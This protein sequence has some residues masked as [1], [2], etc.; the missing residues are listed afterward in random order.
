MSDKI[1]YQFSAFPV[2]WLISPKLTANEKIVLAV[3]IALGNG[4]GQSAVGYEKLAGYCC[5]SR[6]YLIELINKL[7]INGYIERTIQNNRRKPTL[8]RVC[9]ERVGG[10][11]QAAAQE[12]V[13][14]DSCAEKQ[15][16]DLTETGVRF[17][18][19][20]SQFEQT[21]NIFKQD[22]NYNKGKSQFEQTLNKSNKD[23]Y[24]A[25]ADVAAVRSMP[26]GEQVAGNT[27][28][29]EVMDAAKAAKE[30][31][32]IQVISKYFGDKMAW[33]QVFEVSNKIGFRVLGGR[34][35][36]VEIDVAKE[37]AAR[38]NFIFTDN[39]QFADERILTA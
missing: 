14:A 37:F 36:G 33:I 7:E 6:T 29:K 32:S 34:I 3:L 21:L 12:S 23:S 26:T 15:E 39:Q 1:K 35:S 8:C 9:L 28:Q 30:R 13:R 17:G 11:A 20:K 19:N 22:L 31:E 24:I 25:T 2:E 16:S 38:H 18:E 4:A 27:Q 10:Q 5:L